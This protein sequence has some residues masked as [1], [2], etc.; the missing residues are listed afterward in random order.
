MNDLRH[1]AT[2]TLPQPPERVF[3]ALTEPAQ[4]RAWF[5]EHVEV[6]ARNGGAFRFWGRHTYGAPGR[7]EAQQRISRIEPPRL[8][9]YGWRIAGCQSEITLALEP[10]DVDGTHGTRL[11]VTHELSAP[12][13][14]ARGRALIDD[15]WRIQLS[16]LTAW[17]RDPRYV[18][19][20]DFADP[21]PQVRASILIDA[22]REQVFR[23]LLD[24]RL[25]DRWIAAAASVEPR[26]GGRYAYGWSYEIDGRSV[27]GGPTRILELVPNE[28][29]VTDWPDWRGDPDAPGTTVTWLLATEGTGTRVTVIHAGFERTVDL[30]DYPF[31]WR[32]FLEALGK[33]ATEAVSSA[34]G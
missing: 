34:A 3:A 12:L 2:V 11:K 18:S 30:S 22:T 20:P 17:L 21:H 16:N 4:L 8:L 24:P 28:K 32:G 25:L 7:S 29:L 15:L 10:A 26:A 33:V 13:P 23:A 9:A 14:V 19:L 5:A 6:E 31:G 1:E 27:S